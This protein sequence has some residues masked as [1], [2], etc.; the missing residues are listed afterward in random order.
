MLSEAYY[1]DVKNGMYDG[2]TVEGEIEDMGF[3]INGNL[4]PLLEHC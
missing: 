2:L 1:E 4:P 3:D